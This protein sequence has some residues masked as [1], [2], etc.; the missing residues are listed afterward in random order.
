MTETLSRPND[1]SAWRPD[2]CRCSSSSSPRRRQ[3]SLARLN[4]QGC[5]R[6]L[7]A[8][9]SRFEGIHRVHS[10]VGASLADR[11]RL[12]PLQSRGTFRAPSGGLANRA[13]LP[14]LSTIRMGQTRKYPFSDLANCRKNELI[15]REST[16][17]S[18]ARA[19]EH[20]ARQR[21]YNKLNPREDSHWKIRGKEKACMWSSAQE[22]PGN[23]FRV[24]N[25]ANRTRFS[26]ACFRHIR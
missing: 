11:S 3:S 18:F 2:L 26:A 5:R 19:A 21:V 1:T 24:M 15:K 4:W 25:R 13:R 17:S 22:K 12:P 16:L 20:K 6:V 23:L 9:W 10:R 7:A 14:G 8:D